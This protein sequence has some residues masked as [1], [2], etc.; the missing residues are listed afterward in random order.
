MA[1]K[2]R[3]YRIGTC[4]D[5]GRKRNVTRIRFWVNAMPY[6]VCSDCIRPYRNRILTPHRIDSDIRNAPQAIGGRK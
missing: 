2:R 6:V 5:C 4:Q 1:K 3:I